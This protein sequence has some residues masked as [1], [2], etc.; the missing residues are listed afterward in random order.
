MLNIKEI[1]KAWAISFNPTEEQREKAEQRL[2]IC[3]SCENKGD[4]LIEVCK[5]CGCPFKSK[6][7]SSDGG[8]PVGKW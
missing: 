8:C 1:V 5:L 7:F 3:K 4:G 6:V 2:E